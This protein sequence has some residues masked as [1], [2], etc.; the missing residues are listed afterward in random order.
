MSNDLKYISYLQGIP[1]LLWLLT[2][3]NEIS[4]TEL[5]LNKS[6]KMIDILP[7]VVVIMHL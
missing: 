7:K 2:F 3:Y 6:Y 4:W 5:F 1:S